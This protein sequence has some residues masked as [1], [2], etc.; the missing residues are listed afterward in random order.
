[1]AP[2]FIPQSASGEEEEEEERGQRAFWH[3]EGQLLSGCLDR[4]DKDIK[5]W[6]RRPLLRGQGI[7]QTRSF[8]CVCQVYKAGG[9]Q[10]LSG[11]PRTSL[12][13]FIIEQQQANAVFG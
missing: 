6:Q 11:G 5:G 8:F 2:A 4:P 7:G 1:M 10:L 12:Y 3:G 13:I 9:N